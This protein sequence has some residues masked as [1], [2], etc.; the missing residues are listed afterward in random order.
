MKSFNNIE[1]QQVIFNAYSSPKYSLKEKKEGGIIEH[2]SICVDEINLY[3]NF[4]NDNL[5]E[6]KY[7][8]TGCAVFISSIEIMIKNLLNK[9]KKEISIILNNY[10]NMINQNEYDKS[11]ELN[12]L[13]VFENV[14]AHLNRLECASIIYRAFKKGING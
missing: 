6:A 2:S 9:S 14:K 10:F 5:I 12:D 7:F 3:L 1:K 13:L 4:K 11:I 8:A